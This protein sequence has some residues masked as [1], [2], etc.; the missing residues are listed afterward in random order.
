MFYFT[1]YQTYLKQE[2]WFT[3]TE[4]MSGKVKYTSSTYPT[5]EETEIIA[6]SCVAHYEAIA[7]RDEEDY[8]NSLKGESST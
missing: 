4:R 2:F 8:Q 3:V 7:H 6:R 1:T 5:V